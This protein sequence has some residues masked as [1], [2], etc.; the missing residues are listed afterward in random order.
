MYV[1]C[2]NSKLDNTVS[3]AQVITKISSPEMLFPP[4][5]KTIIK[6]EKEG[7]SWSQN[8]F[9]HVVEIN[10]RKVPCT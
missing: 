9:L 3:L 1:P 6:K 5:Q 7:I 8:P 2:D 4:Q 10:N